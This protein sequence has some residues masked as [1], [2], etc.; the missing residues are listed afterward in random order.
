MASLSTGTTVEQARGT[1]FGYWY[2]STIPVQ[3]RL[4]QHTLN[5]YTAALMFQIMASS[6]TYY[7]FWGFNPNQ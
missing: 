1:L 6:F 5:T 3:K 7:W 4:H 2:R